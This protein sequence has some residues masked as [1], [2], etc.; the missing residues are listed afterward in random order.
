[1]LT[2]YFDTKVNWK[3]QFFSITCPCYKTKVWEVFQFFFLVVKIML[4][5][6]CLKFF[7]DW[8]QT[9]LKKFDLKKKMI[10]KY[11]EK[12]V[13]IFIYLFIHLFI[14][15]PFFAGGGGRWGEVGGRRLKDL[16]MQ[17][18]ESSYIC[19][20]QVLDTISQNLKKNINQ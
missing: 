12:K 13:L 6:L 9:D 7:E 4:T 17:H 2:L 14:Y 20:I 19:W 8:H 1:M 5:H 16:T 18:V 15:S 10:S 3:N 11:Q